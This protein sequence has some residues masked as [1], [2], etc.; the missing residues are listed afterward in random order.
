MSGGAVTRVLTAALAALAL[1]AGGCGGSAPA[2]R[3]ATLAGPCTA[4]ALTTLAGA[5]AIREDAIAARRFVEP[6]GSAACR[7]AAARSAGGPLAV[8]VELDTAPQAYAHLEREV[9]EYTQGVI[10]FHEGSYADPRD[11]FGLGIYADWFPAKR[12]LLTTDAVI[13]VAVTVRSVPRREPPASR[14]R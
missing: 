7:F 11:V 6:D 2:G 8:T 3:R 1:A 12:Q 5:A 14:R 9:V 13:I 10:W 4:R